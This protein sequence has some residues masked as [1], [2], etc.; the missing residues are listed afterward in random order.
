MRTACK[1]KKLLLATHHPCIHSK[2]TNPD[3]N[4][5]DKPGQGRED[6]AHGAAK[7]DTQTPRRPG[8]DKAV[9]KGADGVATAIVVSPFLPNREPQQ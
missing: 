9:K 1:Q 6:M 5:A 3:P 8:P 4:K 2:R 7:Q